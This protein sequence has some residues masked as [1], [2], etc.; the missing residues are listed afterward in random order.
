MLYM[1]HNPDNDH[2]LQVSYERCLEIAFTSA[3][4][5]TSYL[6]SYSRPFK[7]KKIYC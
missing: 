5:D 6:A 7:K 1:D 2:A 3:N 4:I